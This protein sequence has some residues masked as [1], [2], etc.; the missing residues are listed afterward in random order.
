MDELRA[1]LELATEQELQELTE[2]LF[3]RKLNPWDY[4]HTPDPITVQAQDRDCW[5]DAIEQ[6]FRFLAADG[7]TV[8]KGQSQTI[9]YRQTLMRV[10]RYL[11]IPFRPSWTTSE[12]ES[13]IFLALLQR[14]WAKLPD[15]D[16]QVM[17]KEVQKSLPQL[18]QHPDFTLQNI[19][20]LLEGSA[21]IAMSSLMRR[22]IVQQVTR[23]FALQLTGQQFTRGLFS[24]Q[25]ATLGITRFAVARSALVCFSTALWIWFIADLGWRAIATN[26]GRIIPTIFTIAQIRLTRGEE[27]LPAY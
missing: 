13:E 26:Y 16:R 3:Q 25:G 27:W 10:C 11:K 24:A 23:Q 1:A 19:R 7:M 6:R 9:S 22:L 21:A 14:M 17:S 15:Q 2:I 20:L 18:A 12:L 4:F 5:L 8:L